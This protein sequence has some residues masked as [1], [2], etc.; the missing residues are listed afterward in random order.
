MLPT[1]PDPLTSTGT[2]VLGVADE[3]AFGAVGV[4]AAGVAGGGATV[5]TPPVLGGVAEP[6]GAGAG[7]GRGVG[8]GAGAGVACADGAGAGVATG[9]VTASGIAVGVVAGATCTDGAVPVTSVAGAGA[10]AS[11][12]VPVTVVAGA[13][14]GAVDGFAMLA[15][16]SID[17]V[18]TMLM[19]ARA[20][21]PQRPRRRAG[22][23]LATDLVAGAGARCAGR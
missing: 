12:G 2:V 8:W 14:A 22:L 18:V 7:A 15:K 9:L 3:G 5:A 20:M 6:A 4:G 17:T 13:L 23:A 11:V 1:V 16:T 10:G 19:V 21:M